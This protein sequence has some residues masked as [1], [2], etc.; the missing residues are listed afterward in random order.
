[1]PFEPQHRLQVWQPSLQPSDF[2][3]T[4]GVRCGRATDGHQASLEG[5]GESSVVPAHRTNC[6]LIEFGRHQDAMRCHRLHGHGFAHWC[7][8]REGRHFLGMA[9]KSVDVRLGH[10]HGPAHRRL[11]TVS[12]RHGQT[13]QMMRP[14][15]GANMIQPCLPGRCVPQAVIELT[16]ARSIV[17]GITPKWEAHKCLR[18]GF[19]TRMTPGI[20]VTIEREHENRT[21]RLGETTDNRHEQKP[22]SLAILPA[23]LCGVQRLSSH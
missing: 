1:M 21:D 23:I 13:D 10:M 8:S 19:S 15:R 7:H 3:V 17:H 9:N 11:L 18:R 2:R 20:P 22:M 14:Q 6:R 16:N 4:E 12:A 5:Q